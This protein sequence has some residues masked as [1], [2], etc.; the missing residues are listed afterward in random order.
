MASN[1]PE[2]S[3]AGALVVSVFCE[4]DAPI[5]KVWT[6]LLDFPKYKEWNPFVQVIT[7]KNKKPLEDQTPGEGKYL[8]M[9]VHI[10]PTM[11]D[12][13]S[14]TSA[15]EQITS[16]Q[17][18]LHRLAWKNLLPSWFIRAERWQALRTNEAGKTVYETR[19]VFGGIGAYLI[20]WFLGAK[21]VKSFEE[22][23]KGLKLYSEQN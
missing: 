19:E 8:L 23:A 18:E 4:I 14:T 5:E 6:V 15:F 7:D 9:Q 20:K 22:M 12:S 16:V 13:I 10:P 2:P 17:P 11:D 21:L 1:L 3:Y